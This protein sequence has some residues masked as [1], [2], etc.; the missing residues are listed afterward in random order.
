MKRY[1]LIWSLYTKLFF[2]YLLVAGVA[3]HASI[4]S[5]LE[6]AV[7]DLCDKDIALLGEAS[8]GDGRTFHFK[9]ELVR[10]LVN[11]CHYNAF[12]IESGIYDFL[13]FNRRLASGSEVEASTI[14]NA[15]G[16]LW[17]STRE[18]APLIPF[19]FE[20]AKSGTLIIGGLDDQINSTAYY[21]LKEMPM[22]LTRFLQGGEQFKCLSKIQRYVLQQYDEQNPYSP[23]DQSRILD[24][25]RKVKRGIA[26]STSVSRDIQLAMVESF[27]RLVK[28]DFVTPTSQVFNGRDRSMF[29]NFR[30]LESH[31]ATRSKI[32]FWGN[33]VHVAKDLSPVKGQEGTVPLGAYI[34]REFGNRSTAL[35]FSA[36]SGSYAMYHQPIQ[37]MSVAP[38]DSIEGWA[39]VKNDSN[40]RYLTGEQ[41]QR[42]GTTSARPL[43]YVFS[44]AKWYEVLDR[45]LVFREERP[46]HF[47]E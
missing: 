26:D 14:A 39:L 45:L 10:R 43:G 28:R 38:F 21:A 7:R 4:S 12:F 33:T 35:G 27:T 19:L 15:T 37:N 25:L 46:P 31:L 44:T 23:A 2:V 17:A 1:S 20:K 41:L 29:L 5:E 22:E 18:F 9:V 16:L 13:D 40:S 11:E 36:Y 32:M 42:L 3:G 34:H 6:R 8:H 47:F 24:C 30:W